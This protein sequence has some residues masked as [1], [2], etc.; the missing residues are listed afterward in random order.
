M[1]FLTTI[2]ERKRER[3]GVA[4]KTI[5]RT[6]LRER[7]YFHRRPF[8]LRESLAAHTIGIIAEMKKASP[9]KGILRHQYEPITIAQNYENAGASALSVLTEEDFFCGSL[10]H[11]EIIREKIRLP[12][13][14]KDFI[15]D[16][17]QL[18]EARSAGADAILLIAAA[19]DS[20][21][22]REL[23][24]EATELALEVLVEIHSAKELETLPLE[25]IS[26]IGINNRN[27][28]T[29]TVNLATSIE[30]AKELPSGLT[31]VSESGITTSQDIALLW[32]SGIK[33]YL[34]GEAF[35]KAQNPGNALAQLIQEAETLC[36]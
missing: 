11:I 31:I 4:K 8:S 29:F 20:I 21:L 32:K 33:N 28:T 24:E 36:L 2:L 27:L 19:L 17:Y 5:S 18:T 9:S 14:R 23:L 15:I 35:M 12:L 7:E 10:K 16:S 25:R 26:L 22:L 1:N 30:L 3:L 13:L 34:I 6:E